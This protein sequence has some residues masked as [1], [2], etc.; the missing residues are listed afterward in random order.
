MTS[1]PFSLDDEPLPPPGPSS[2]P[3]AAA[4]FAGG[5]PPWLAGL[6]PE[7]REAVT[8]T[9]GPVLV[10]SG[11]GTGKT[12]V[13]TTRLA[14]ILGLR[15]AQPWQCL[16][17][18]FTNRAAREMRD[19][20]GA[21]I[22]PMADSVWLGT[23]HA[24]CVRILRRHAEAVGLKSGFTILDTDDQM[25]LLKQLMEAAAFDTKK[26]PAQ[27]V[28]GI[29]QRWKDRALTPETVPADEAR[30]GGGQKTVQLYTDYQARLR[31][32]NACDF[33]DLLL[34][35]VGLFQ[36]HPE[37]L[38]E[39]QDRFRYILVDEYQD[40][41]VAQYLWLR[42]LA[43]KHK[44]ICCVGDDDQCFVAGTRVTMAD[45][46]LRPIEDVA[47]G[48]AV[49][50]CYGSGDYRASEVLRVHRKHWQGEGVRIITT[51]GRELVSTPEHM[52]FAGY[53]LGSTP[54]TF[55]TYLMFRRG[56][57]FRLGTSQV[58]TRSQ[59]KA[60]VGFR[61]RLLQEHGDALW[62]IGTHDREGEARLNEYILSLRYAI[63]TLPFV[64][65]RG[66][67]INGLVHD[68]GA[69]DSLFKTFDTE[70]AAMRLLADLGL[71]ADYPHHRAR[72]R[73]SKRRN[74][75][76]TLCGD[77]RGASPLHRISIVG[78][79]AEGRERVAAAGFSVRTA[80]AGS[81]SWRVETANAD[82]GV[83]MDQARRLAG[84]FEDANI[85]TM[86]RLGR[87]EDGEASNSLPMIPAAS[88][89]PGMVMATADGSYDVV[90]TVERISLR[91][92]VHDL[93]VARTHNFVAEGIVTHNSIYSWRGAEVG[94]IL[95]FDQ[96]FPG[97]RIVRLERNYRSTPTILRAASHL[98]RHNQGRLG[99]ELRAPGAAEDGAKVHV[100]GVWSQDDEARWLVEEVEALQRAG[101]K[102]GAMAILV[103][104]GFQTREFE[105]RLI[106]TGIPYRVIGGPRFYERMEIRDALAYLRL[107]VSPD[108]DLAFE[109]VVNKPKR[110]LGEATIQ[111]LHVSARALGKALYP[112]A[113]ELVQTDELK[114]KAR[115]AL[116]DFIDGMERW[117]A[118]IGHMDLPEL[119]RTVV[120]ES[121]YAEMWRRDKSPEAPGRLEN[122]EELYGA[123]AEYETLL[124]FLE[125]ISLVM[126]NEAKTAD[127][128]GITLMTLH[129]AKG[130]EFDVV[131]LP[132]WEEEI[133]PSKR[134]LEENG[135]A[136]LEEERRLAYVGLTRARQR[137]YISFAASRRIY[138]QWVNTVPSRFIDELPPECVERQ[139]ESGLYGAG[140]AESGGA[141]GSSWDDGWAG[142]RK[143]SKVI[144]GDGLSWNVKEREASG[145]FGVGD[146]VFHQKFGYGTITAIEDDKLAVQ[147]DKA[148][149]KKVLAGFVEAG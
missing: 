43:R 4:A 109:R 108:D 3:D 33:G 61:Q 124:Q 54:Q 65:R 127:D 9:E 45:G 73:N 119:V 106:T 49:L 131:F 78:N 6:N 1:D 57:G 110:G 82:L 86:A 97:A 135:Q 28:M 32:L 36:S 141:W 68:Q 101:S 96:D 2:A 88:V 26:F 132:G 104:A 89:R 30:A 47:A 5:E 93:D 23:F 146:R 77:R 31:E 130:L 138:N 51:G 63:P 53:R 19:R 80:R 98:I 8:T 116:R 95:K 29:I 148:G 144:P 62:I 90:K 142:R 22:G 100:R 55:F 25:R 79:D 64:A 67:S 83:V 105:E 14:H 16:A 35:C 48:D 128:P 41:N 18:T 121:G 139:S 112:T 76:V 27:M 129:A 118:L 46:T 11:A 7:Q 40:T 85:I 99:K 122:L 87:N 12:R 17:V 114:P 84:C 56:M 39:Y 92:T 72:S 20:L 147:F 125:H 120:E 149:L 111:M 37:I 59:A 113:A 126:E 66:G 81:A 102:L 123:V 115:A 107:L 58:Y 42:L 38:A 133:F 137:V 136:A 34:L 15:L 70:A 74:I 60:V 71:S 91:T 44:N 145:S 21:M 50:S 117:K 24:L 13:L 143:S 52:H 134:S 69:L 75:V 94:N 140:F 10:L 103:R